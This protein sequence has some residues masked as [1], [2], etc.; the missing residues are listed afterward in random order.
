MVYEPLIR[1]HAAK[2]MVNYAVNILGMQP[3]VTRV[4]TF[5]DMKNQSNEMQLYATLA[6]QLGIMGV[7]NDIAKTPASNFNGNVNVARSQFGTMLSRSIYVNDPTGTNSCWY[8][9]HLNRLKIDDVMTKIDTPATI[10]TR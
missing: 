4:C 2:M 6:C 7:E 1:Q 8:C 10:E 3:D 5:E 9:A